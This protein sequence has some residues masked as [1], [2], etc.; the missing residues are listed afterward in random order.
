M[1]INVASPQVL[2]YQLCVGW[3]VQR[4]GTLPR[5]RLIFWDA[6]HPAFHVSTFCF[7]LR[8]ALHISWHNDQA[9]SHEL[10]MRSLES[11]GIMLEWHYIFTPYLRSLLLHLCKRIFALFFILFPQLVIKQT[12][13]RIQ[14]TQVPQQRKEMPRLRPRWDHFCILKVVWRHWIFNLL[15]SKMWPWTTKKC[16]F[17]KLRFF[18]SS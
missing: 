16:P 5:V 3:K 13:P 11:A 10:S 4:E 1:L 8:A 14:K 18:T 17:S 12:S 2:H 9:P 15:W 7:S 6:R